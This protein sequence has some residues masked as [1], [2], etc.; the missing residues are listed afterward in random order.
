MKKTI[1]HLLILLCFACRDKQ[2]CTLSGSLYTDGNTTV[3]TLGMQTTDTLFS[4]MADSTGHFSVTVSSRET[5]FC[6]L[7]GVASTGGERWQFATPV[8]LHPDASVHLDLRLSKKQ[9]SIIATDADN[10]ALQAFREWS[11]AQSRSLWSNPPA[12]TEAASRLALFP[13]EAQR[14]IAQEHPTPATADYLATWANVECLNLAHGLFYGKMPASLASHLPAIPKTLDV[15][16]WSLF[17]GSD[18][19][20]IEYLQGKTPEPEAQI[21][22]LQEEFHTSSIQEKI[23]RKIIENYIRQRPYSEEYLSRLEQ[24]SQGQPDKEALM[25]QFRDKRFASPG[26]PLPDAVFEDREGKEHRLSEFAGKYIYIDLWASWCGPCVAEVPHLQKLEKELRRKDV[27]FVSIS[28][29]TKRENWE[30]KM[31]QLHM[32]GHQWIVR[33]ETFA[34]MMNIKGIPHFLLYGKDGKLLDY[35]APR[36]SHP[37]WKEKLEEL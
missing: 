30:K 20:I 8:A 32:H 26:A 18:L 2:A 35:K 10:R 4:I 28:L 12:E 17:Y 37:A 15:A 3:E 29:D 31:E 21:R 7:F 6:R 13:S 16:Y 27:V 11:L 33:D 34:N 14:I 24:L 9:A 22:L 23:S 36:P 25:Q 19:Y 5:L 1:I